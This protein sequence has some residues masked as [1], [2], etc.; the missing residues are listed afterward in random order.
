MDENHFCS[1]CQELADFIKTEGEQPQPFCMVSDQYEPGVNGRISVSQ[2]ITAFNTVYL[3]DENC[4]L[5]KTA[6]NDFLENCSL[7]T[8]AIFLRVAVEQAHKVHGL[9]EKVMDFLNKI[10]LSI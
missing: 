2:A 8:R 7:K 9:N 10:R 6:L 1:K 3:L 5:S 4:E